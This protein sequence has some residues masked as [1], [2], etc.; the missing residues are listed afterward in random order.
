M[1]FIQNYDENF[2]D[3]V[4]PNLDNIFEAV[5][6]PVNYA[7]LIFKWSS[8]DFDPSSFVNGDDNPVAK[9]AA[10]TFVAD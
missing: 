2:K 1:F 6:E 8:T 7:N 9:I 4:I 10:F 3:T 5:I